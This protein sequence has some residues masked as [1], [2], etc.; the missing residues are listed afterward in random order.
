MSS[1]PA[2]RYV[3]HAERFGTEFVFETA[4]DE[5]SLRQLGYLSLQLQRIDSKWRL[6]IVN[7]KVRRGE[8]L[9]AAEAQLGDDDSDAAIAQA[10]WTTI[11]LRVNRRAAF[12]RD[13]ID[14][15]ETPDLA[16]RMAMISVRTLRR[17]K[18]PEK[19]TQ[20][21]D[22]AA[23][24]LISWDEKRTN[25]PTPTHGSDSAICAPTGPQNGAYGVWCDGQLTLDVEPGR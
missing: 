11:D 14:A 24:P 10:L 4:R 15:G 2:D 6:P 16:C 25:R 9:A 21:P 18:V 22:L 1:H 20:L 5:L 19:V 23:D 13:L 3:K 8:W 12:A 17:A 7:G